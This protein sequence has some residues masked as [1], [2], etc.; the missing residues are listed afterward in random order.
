MANTYT[1]YPGP[2]TAFG[3]YVADTFAE[4]VS[5]ARRIAASGDASAIDIYRAGYIWA[6]GVV[7]N[8]SIRWSLWRGRRIGAERVSTVGG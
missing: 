7:H 2:H 1:V 3:P 6:S 5:Y 8:R 4:A